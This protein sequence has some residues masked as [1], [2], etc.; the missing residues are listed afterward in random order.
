MLNN[1]LKSNSGKGCVPCRIAQAS[2]LVAF[3]AI[4][5]AMSAHFV[6]AAPPAARAGTQEQKNPDTWKTVATEDSIYFDLGS[7]RIDYR[8]SGT[9][10]RHAA[11]LLE[12]PKLSVVLI[13]HTDD[14]GSASI[15]LA[16]GQ[17]RLLA[18]KKR[19]EDLKI[20]AARIRIE[21]HGSENRAGSTC[22]DEECRRKSRRVDFVFRS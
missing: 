19:L 6:F 12:D 10:A 5:A 7:S 11:R 4:S 17:E 16:K 1:S 15:E 14:L 9:I 2:L 18:V 22:T 20:P 3:L 13:A 8:A 21:N